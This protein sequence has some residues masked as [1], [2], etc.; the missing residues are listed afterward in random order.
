[1]DVVEVQVD[2]NRVVAFDGRVLEIFGGSVRRFHANLLSITVPAPDKRGNR[3]VTLHQSATETSLPVDE[4]QFA[5][6]QPVLDAL[7]AAGIEVS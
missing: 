7:K 5:M 6:I 1:V 4:Q 3:D 2:A